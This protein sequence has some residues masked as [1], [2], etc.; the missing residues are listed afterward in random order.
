MSER[1]WLDKDYYKILGVDKSVS[2]ADMKKAYRKL[3]RK[4]H[5]DQNKDNPQAGEKFKEVTAAYEVL[6]N[7]DTRKRYD[8]FRQMGH[9]G[10][11]FTGGSNAYSS[12]NFGGFE[13]VFSMF[14]GGGASGSAGGRRTFYTTS[15]G[16]RGAG[17]FGG[18]MGSGMGGAGGMGAGMGS[19]GIGDFIGSMFS[20]N[21]SQQSSGFDDF[22]GHNANAMKPKPTIL[23]TSIDFDEAVNGKVIALKIANKEVRVKIPQGV[24]NGQV[25][26]V[27]SSS[28]GGKDVRI[29]V[30]VKKHPYFEID[31][32]NVRLM[33]P[34]KFVEL[35]FGVIVEVPTVSGDKVTL[36]IPE[37]SKNLS[38]LR[39]KG[40]GIV[41]KDKKGDLLVK[42][43]LSVPTKLNAKAKAA[44]KEYQKATS[45]DSPRADL[46]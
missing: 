16:Q 42:L 41:T 23:N 44:L 35:G 31:G 19:G 7:E 28:T 20:G 4:L 8:A 22:S 21:S 2:Q 30:S 32:L 15:G 33:F 10:A 9:G 18:G 29:K 40:G 25:I 13:D 6:S 38:V 39:V 27:P 5:P 11:R 24:K 17:G 34:V 14:N 46:F 43:S 1:E 12:Q 36:K 26:K 3:A 45:K 37:N